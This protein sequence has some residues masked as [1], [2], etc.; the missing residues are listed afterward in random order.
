[1]YAGLFQSEFKSHPD[2]VLSELRF[3]M[4]L[5]NGTTV[6]RGL[7]DMSPDALDYFRVV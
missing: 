2:E 7:F 1:M 4:L 3:I 6:E 5:P